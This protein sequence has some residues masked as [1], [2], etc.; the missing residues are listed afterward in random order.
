MS[1]DAT[2][3]DVLPYCCQ[4][5]GLQ[6]R[7]C[8]AASS[9]QLRTISLGML[10]DDGS[11]LLVALRAA[12]AAASPHQHPAAA[13]A[14]AEQTPRA[15]FVGSA[16]INSDKTCKQHL[17]AIT[18]LLSHTPTAA[19]AAGVAER[20]LQVPAVPM[21]C[22]KQLLA[23]GMT[24]TYAQLVAAANSMVAGVEVWVQAQ[25]ELGLHTDIPQAAVTI[26][27]PGTWPE[28][29]LDYL[30]EVLRANSTPDLLQLAMNCSGRSAALAAAH[31]LPAQ[32][33]PLLLR[34][35]LLT[36]AKRMHDA[37]TASA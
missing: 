17:Q 18:W 21:Q 31:S 19:A 32:L 10:H 25:Q 2:V 23:A 7:A 15:A 33:E 14:R 20:A 8:L 11:M 35:L 37:P 36:A 4:Q 27:C 22:A 1:G 6:G 13:A 12:A 26:C 28:E 34:K 16:S 29:T 3:F 24:V 9:R 5:L 30:T